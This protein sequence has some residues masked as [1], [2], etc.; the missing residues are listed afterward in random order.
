MLHNYPVLHFF[1]LYWTFKTL[2]TDEASIGFMHQ[3]SEDITI[4]YSPGSF[5]D[6]ILKT[7]FIILAWS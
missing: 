6:L 4:K 5:N 7:D 3:N 1:T 2:K